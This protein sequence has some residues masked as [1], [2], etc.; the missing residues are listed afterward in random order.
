[1][2]FNK[3][4]AWKVVIP[5][6][7]TYAGDL[8]YFEG[9]DQLS[10]WWE[11]GTGDPYAYIYASTDHSEV[12]IPLYVLER[13]AAVF[14]SDFLKFP[15]VADINAS[16]SVIRVLHRQTPQPEIPNTEQ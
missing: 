2:N 12:P 8:Y 10:L 4:T 6:P 7:T 16:E 11:F 3:E 14:Q 5:P 15:T 1:M 9:D 13:I